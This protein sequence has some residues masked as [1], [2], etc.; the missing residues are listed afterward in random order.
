MRPA[1][2]CRGPPRCQSR[3]VRPLHLPV[4]PFGGAG[5][6]FGLA[7]HAVLDGVALAAA[8]QVEWQI[9]GESQLVLA[10]LGVFLAIL[11]HKPL[12][13]MTVVLFA[14]RYK[15]GR[16]AKNTLLL[17]YA[18]LCPLT[19]ALLLYALPASSAARP[20]FVAAALAFSAGMFLCI[21]LGDL[22]P[23]I[24]FHDH[25]RLIMTTVLLLGILLAWSLKHVESLH[26]EHTEVHSAAQHKMYAAAQHE[27]HGAAR[28]HLKE[29][30]INITHIAGN[31][32][33]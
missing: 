11:L 31:T 24:H 9:G 4:G 7:V 16:G 29:A 12:D 6:L 21:A 26:D 28:L 3:S 22:L 30:L 20:E 27:V 10:G 15:R 17:A 19:A 2:R 1:A 33:A 14:E 5:V 18:L 8:M 23:E 32:V 25:D 13:A